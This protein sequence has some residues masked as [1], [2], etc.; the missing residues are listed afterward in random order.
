MPKSQINL[1]LDND[2]VE[3]LD[4]LARRTGR[5]KTFYAVQAIQQF[6]DDREDY[7]LAKDSLEAFEASGEAVL[8]PMISAGG[9]SPR[10]ES[11]AFNPARRPADGTTR[12]HIYRSP[13]P[14]ASPSRIAQARIDRLL[15]LWRLEAHR[16]ARVR[17]ACP[18]E[19]HRQHL[20]AGHLRPAGLR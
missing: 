5:T 12:A 6:L 14:T 18:S 8:T 9:H 4:A 17:T 2:M 15:V 13:S 16:R 10:D 19:P 20:P 7:F 3:R 1:R 11:G